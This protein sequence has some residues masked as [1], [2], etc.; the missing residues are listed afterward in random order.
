M[1]N[2]LIYM[3]GEG[4]QSQAYNETQCLDLST[5]LW[6]Q[7]AP[8]HTGRHGSG[9]VLHNNKIYIAAGSPNKGGGNLPTI[10][11]FTT[12]HNYG[13]LFDGKSLN[14]WQVKAQKK[15]QGKNFWSVENGAIY[16]NSMGDTEH[17]YVWLLSENEYGDF[18]LRLKFRVSR[19]HKGNAGVQF[20][21]RYDEEAIV[22][23]NEKG[24]L[25]GPQ[26]DIDPQ[27]PWRNGLICI[28]L[29]NFI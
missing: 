3:G 25:D 5:G 1:N 10:D 18:E 20:R 12:N 23:E 17:G 29:V 14:G 28:F 24:W 15:D 11:V 27:S 16:C 6:S 2:N 19:E 8:M 21:S 13:K 9:A 7:L 22:L 4:V 26:A